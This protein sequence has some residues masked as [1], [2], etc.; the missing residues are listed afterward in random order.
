MRFWVCKH[1]NNIVSLAERGEC[2]DGSGAYF[3]VEKNELVTFHGSVDSAELSS[4]G[5]DHC[6]ILHVL[7]GVN[8]LGTLI[9]NDMSTRICE[10]GTSPPVEIMMEWTNGASLDGAPMINRIDLRWT[11]AK[12]KVNPNFGN[13]DHA[14]P[15]ASGKIAPQNM[16]MKGNALGFDMGVSR[17]H[18]NTSK[19]VWIFVKD[20]LSE[21]VT[22]ADE[23]TLVA[24]K[25]MSY[26][27]KSEPVRVANEVGAESIVTSQEE[28]K[29]KREAKRNEEEGD[30]SG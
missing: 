2:I 28:R 4:L 12:F 19:N 6:V 8:T 26:D 10:K 14:S 21:K 15:G 30:K 27:D 17:P 7:Y 11:V 16:R 23:F 24:N 1:H 5:A 3:L 13:L 9:F 22:L 18:I 20:L 29:R 25:K